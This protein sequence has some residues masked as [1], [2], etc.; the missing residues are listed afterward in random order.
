[1][2][3]FSVVSFRLLS[4]HLLSF[5]LLTFRLLS[6]RL[7]LI[8]DFLIDAVPHGIHIPLQGIDPIL[9]IREALGDERGHTIYVTVQRVACIVVGHLAI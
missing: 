2:L 8:G 1:M 9:V 4:F 6:F 5:R 3:M 7:L